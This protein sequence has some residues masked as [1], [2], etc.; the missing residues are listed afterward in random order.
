MDAVT[1]PETT[2]SNF[3]ME[4]VIPLRIASDAQPYATD[5]NVVWTPTIITLDAEGN[6]HHRTTGFFSPEELIPSIKLGTGKTYF[7]TGRFDETIDHFDK[8]L[9]DYPGSGATPEAMYWRGVAGYKS[10]GNPKPLK[11]AY[12]R[13]KA[14]YSDSEWTRRAYPYRL[15]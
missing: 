15:L 13:L 7:D 14:E 5:F 8:L 10:T 6:E 4:H 2:V 9:A 3:I 11:E 12:E 1:Y